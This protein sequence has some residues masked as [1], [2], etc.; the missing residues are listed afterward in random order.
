MGR[1]GSAKGEGRRAAARREA[2]NGWVDLTS[3][4]DLIRLMDANRLVEIEIES[5][6]SKI[7]LVRDQA[8]DRT[9]A[10]VVGAAAAAT[11]ADG[12]SAALPGPA[13]VPREDHSK[14]II[15]PMVGTFYRAPSP[16]APPFV[17]VGSIVEKGD[18]LCIIEAMKMMNEIEAEFRGRVTR[19]VATTGQTVEYGEELF[20]IEPL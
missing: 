6:G 2:K 17:E 12:V 3:V 13:P 4:A 5:G 18:T 9:G 10:P 14:P 16:D 8:H 15:S 20:F 1:A 19:A 7:R 11:P